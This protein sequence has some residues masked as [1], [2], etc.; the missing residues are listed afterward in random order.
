MGS[1]KT[2]GVWALGLLLGIAMCSFSGSAGA[3]EQEALPQ[4]EP[5]E[6]AKAFSLSSKTLDQTRRINVYLPPSY[7]GGK[8]R[9]P[10]LYLLDGGVQEDFIHI[11]GIASLAADFRKIREFVVIGI[12]G[13]DRYQDL[14]SPSTV[15]SDRERLPTSGGAAA[16]RT[17]LTEE[18]K[19]F[20]Q[21]H[22]R[23]TGEAVIMG[24]SAAGLF[25]VETLL[26]QPDLFTGYIAISP[27]MWWNDQSLAKVSGDLLKRPFPAGR[28]LFLTIGD[29]GG[30]MREGVDLLAKALKERSSP[31]LDWTFV[32]MENET[33]GTIFHPAALQALR[34]FFATVD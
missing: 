9:Y 32:P 21:K 24:E 29:E 22:F 26:R 3:K 6:I 15:E 1:G 28:R 33:H 31:Q 23:L 2:Y 4:G 5:I 7:D 34:Q 11:A 18:L 10:T 30:T 17:F 27:M 25:V 8:E 16:F 12:E 20:A 13:I 19:P 14:I